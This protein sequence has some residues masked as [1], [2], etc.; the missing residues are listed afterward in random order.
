MKLSTV[1]FVDLLC[2]AQKASDGFQLV[3]GE[4]SKHGPGTLDHRFMEPPG[5]FVGFGLK[6]YEDASA[7]SFVSN[8][9]HEMS[10]FEPIDDERHRPRTQMATCRQISGGHSAPIF[11]Q[12]DAMKIGSVDSKMLS[13][14]GVKAVQCTLKS[15]ERVPELARN[16]L[17][18]PR[19][20]TTFVP[21]KSS[22]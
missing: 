17:K 19:V 11:D 15:A 5:S 18:L 14:C 3:D 12:V 20:L 13:H 21:L 10:P 4:M 6:L 8:P 16:F 7:V 1:S 22:R 9:A 2:L